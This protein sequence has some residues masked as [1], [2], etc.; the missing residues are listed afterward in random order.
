MLGPIVHRFRDIAGFLCSLPHPY[1]TLI[2]GVFP[3]DHADHPC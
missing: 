3:L 1:F 2:L